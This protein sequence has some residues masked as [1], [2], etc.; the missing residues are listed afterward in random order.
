MTIT[1]KETNGYKTF[2]LDNSMN[3][4]QLTVNTLT[5]AALSLRQTGHLDEEAINNAM[6]LLNIGIDAAYVKGE[7]TV[8][9]EQYLK[10]LEQVRNVQC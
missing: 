3:Y 10:A 8:E 7:S 2:T 6:L 1:R 5:E 9:L 4:A